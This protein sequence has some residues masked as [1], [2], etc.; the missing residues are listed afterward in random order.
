MSEKYYLNSDIE[1]IKK[2]L[3][4]YK[5]NFSGKNFLISVA[6]G[7]LDELDDAGWSAN[8]AAWIRSSAVAAADA[9]A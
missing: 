1:E 6:N 9:A 5:L 8:P 3:K 7:F 4:I 2:N